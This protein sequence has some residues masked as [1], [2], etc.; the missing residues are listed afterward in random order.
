MIDQKTSKIISAN[1][2]CLR[3]ESTGKQLLWLRVDQNI[4]ILASFFSWRFQHSSSMQNVHVNC[5]HS[6]AL[7]IMFSN[8]QA[9]RFVHSLSSSHSTGSSVMKGPSFSI[10]LAFLS[11]GFLQKISLLW[12]KLFVTLLA[13]CNVALPIFFSFGNELIRSFRHLLL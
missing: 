5:P 9:H 11:S 2:K 10:F 8:P 13:L 7:E 4:V 12:G 3:N 1:W 6:F